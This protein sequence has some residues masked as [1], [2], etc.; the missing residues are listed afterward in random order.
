MKSSIIK[1]VRQTQFETYVTAFIGLDFK[2]TKA[3]K[4]VQ[5]GFE[6]ISLFKGYFLMT[7]KNCAHVNCVHSFS[8]A[9][10]S[11][12]PLTFASGPLKVDCVG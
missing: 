8:T 12:L 7:V 1:A 4:V 3:R 11:A 5:M 10:F 6:I 2:R 9:I